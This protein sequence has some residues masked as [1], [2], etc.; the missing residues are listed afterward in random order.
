MSLKILLA[1][2]CFSF[3]AL[4]PL[5]AQP[6][7]LTEPVRFLA[8][9]DSY[10]FGQGVSVQERWPER[11][12]A[13]LRILGYQVDEL[14]LIAQTGWRTDNLRNAINGQMPL[15]GYN[16]VS[17]LIGVNNQY[18]G[19][20]IQTY[21]TE[22]EQLL[23]QAIS[24]AGNNPN[25]VFVLSIPDY[26]YTPYGNGSPAISS[27]IDQFN[28]VNRFITEKYNIRYVNITP[29]SRNGLSDPTL[30]AS[31][32]LHP[33]GKQ[34]NFW[35]TEILKYIEREVSAGEKDPGAP[36]RLHGRKLTLRQDILP[37]QLQVI[38]MQGQTIRLYEP[39]DQ[40]ISLED[41]P[42]GIYLLRLVDRAGKML[43][44]KIL[45]N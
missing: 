42:A 13:E 25:R 16:L 2:L 41:L 31:D 1:A 39:A 45:L 37:Q 29:I 10:T 12:V 32:G 8:L 23:Q 26:A 43:S 40:T 30:V 3:L 18:Q 19:G 38:N 17:L 6:V 21:M 35:V 15:D 36:I 7:I 33:S 4:R 20:S 34:Y 24:L 5:H 28:S 14:R 9:G 22:F 27:A 11:L 44:G